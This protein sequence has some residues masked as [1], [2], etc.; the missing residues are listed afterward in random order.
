MSRSRKKQNF[1][2]QHDFSLETCPLCHQTSCEAYSQ[3]KR[4][5]YLQCTHCS[6]VFV[7]KAFYLTAE[8]EKAEYDLHQNAFDDDG[9]RAFLSRSFDPVVERVKPNA[10]GL[11]FGCG[12]GPVLASMFEDAGHKMKLYDIFYHPETSVLSDQYDFVTCTEVIEHVS[13]PASVIPL[14]FGLLKPEAVLAMMTKRVIDQAAFKN[15]HYKNDQT[16][17]CFYSKETFEWIASKFQMSCE[18]IG[19]DVVIFSNSFS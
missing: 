13:D 11:D 12:P 8:Q 1:F 15:W 9:Y 6:L 4:R 3:D 10:F 14:L 18:F 19:D 2:D 7:P 16:H 17:I 5:P